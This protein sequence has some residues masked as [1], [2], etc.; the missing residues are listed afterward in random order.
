MCISLRIV[1]GRLRATLLPACSVAMECLVSFD[2]GMA[3]LDTSLAFAHLR[4]K[5]HDHGSEVT[6][7]DHAEE[8]VR[9]RSGRSF[10]SAWL[11]RA[12]V[13]CMDGFQLFLPDDFNEMGLCLL[14][15]DTRQ[16]SF[17]DSK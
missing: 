10:V 16:Q 8:D 4:S 14:L 17:V 15:L 11:C 6:A 12:T 3:F 13:L 2:N 7:A 9:D 1:I 5:C